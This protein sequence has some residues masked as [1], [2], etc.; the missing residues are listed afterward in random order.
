MHRAT[1]P[2]RDPPAPRPQPVRGLE[3]PIGE[4]RAQ[5]HH[6]VGAGALPGPDHEQERE[7]S[8]GPHACQQRASP[9]EGCD[10]ADRDDHPHRGDG[11]DGVA[12]TQRDGSEIHRAVSIRAG[13]RPA[14]PHDR[15]PGWK[16]VEGLRCLEDQHQVRQHR[17]GGDSDRGRRPQAEASA[18]ED[19]PGRR[20]HREQRRPREVLLSEQLIERH[21]GDPGE[22]EEA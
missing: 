18:Q 22:A 11:K 12:G 3:G 5:E 4:Q 10:L 17:Q 9:S 21:Q 20:Q 15:A 13:D 2:V 19:H 7:Q 16:S 1:R 14:E 6:D 8:D